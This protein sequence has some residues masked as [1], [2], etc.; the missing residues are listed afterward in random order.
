MGVMFACFGPCTFNKSGC[1]VLNTLKFL[2]EEIGETKQERVAE[3]KARQNEGNDECFHSCGGEIVA[4]SADVAQF[5][6]GSPIDVI[7]LISD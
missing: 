6:K 7:D 2:K 4:D 1:T 3:I 5:K